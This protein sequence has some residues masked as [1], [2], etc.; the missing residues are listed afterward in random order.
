LVEEV[1][2]R[3]NG[4]MHGGKVSP[5]V[6]LDKSSYTNSYGKIWSPLFDVITWMSLDGPA[7]AGSTPPPPPSP[8]PSA[9]AAEQPRRRRVG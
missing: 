1:R 7:P 2:D 5:I 3:L 8:P 9:A 6:R 4:K